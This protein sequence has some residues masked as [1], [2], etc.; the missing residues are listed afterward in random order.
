MLHKYKKIT[1]EHSRC[2]FRRCYPCSGDTA[3][4]LQDQFL[5]NIESMQI[6]S[7]F[8]KILLLIIR[9]ADEYSVHNRSAIVLSSKSSYHLQ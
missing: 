9:I 4:L 3:P 1:I 7:F 5:K 8:L 2:I 6:Y